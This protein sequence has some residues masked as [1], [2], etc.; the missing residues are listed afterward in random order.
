MNY[1]VDG[2]EQFRAKKSVSFS[3]KIF[4]HSMPPSVSPIESPLGQ[5]KQLTT[6]ADEEH[7]ISDV[8]ND[9]IDTYHQRQQQQRPQAEPQQLQQQQIG[10]YIFRMLIIVQKTREAISTAVPLH[11]VNYS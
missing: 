1:E 10:R 4:Y 7:N 11:D 5:N 3:E 6:P 2:A 8:I 9:V